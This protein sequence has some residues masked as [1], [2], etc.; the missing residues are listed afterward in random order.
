MRRLLFVGILSLLPSVV[1][2]QAPIDTTVIHE[3]RV[4]AREHSRVMD[5]AFQL[6]DVLGPRL[7][8]TPYYRRAGEWTI[9][10]LEAMGLQNAHKEPVPWERGWS[11]VY[12]SVRM[13][14]PQPGTMIAAAVPWSPGTDGAVEGEPILVSLPGWGTPADYETFF[15]TWRG[16]L[17]GRII[18]ATDTVPSAEEEYV[19]LLPRHL[20]DTALDSLIRQQERTAAEQAVQEQVEEYDPDL[21]SSPDFFAYQD[22]LNQFLRDQGVLAILYGSANQGGTIQL[23]PGPMRLQPG[24]LRFTDHVLPPPSAIVASEQYNRILRL[25]RR[26]IPV[27]IGL[28]IR[29]TFYQDPG[30]AFNIIA[31]IPG[32]DKKDEIVMAGAHFDSWALGT[33]ATDN[34]AGVAAIMEAMRILKAIGV[35][36]RR[37]IRIAFWAGE[38]GGGFGSRAYVHEHF[39]A[40]Y[41]LSWLEEDVYGREHEPL[42]GYDKLSAYYN[43]DYMAGGI[44]GI[45]LQGNEAAR[46]I[47]QAWLAPFR[48]DGAYHVSGVTGGGS[49]HVSFDDVGLPGFPFIQDGPDFTVSTHHTN[50]D[51]YDYLSASDLKQSAMIMAA[52]L[53]ET[54]MR[55]EMMPRKKVEG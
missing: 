3:I 41:P 26:G 44:R 27:R 37:T 52:F 55:D 33:G 23:Q 6:S 53:Y 40:G 2:A 49:D 19:E 45:F 51:V 9:K 28:D 1:R 22:S 16:K 47:F 36:P 12:T 54:A 5:Y 10:Q 25:Y 11:D 14:A 32:T 39:D 15:D 24:W 38:E 43:L 35:E 34:A 50:M 48:N 13:I 7:T 8:G 17:D 18:L 30:N 46:P 42:P 29:T 20:S 31:E 21:L 4:E